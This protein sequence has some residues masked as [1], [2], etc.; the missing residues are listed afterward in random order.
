M[1]QKQ[2]SYQYIEQ[3]YVDYIALQLSLS[4]DLERSGDSL[5]FAHW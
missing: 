1:R 2:P 3:R 5:L 4:K